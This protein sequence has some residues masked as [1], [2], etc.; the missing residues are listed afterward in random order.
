MLSGLPIKIKLILLAGV[1]VVGALILSYLVAVDAQRR[2][3][4]AK[5]L[6]SIEDLAELAETIS[7]TVDAIQDERMATAY[8]LGRRVENAEPTLRPQRTRVDERTQSLKDFFTSRD[9]K[10]LPPRL[11][12]GIRSAMHILEKQGEVR[13]AVLKEG[14]QLEELN[15]HSHAAIAELVGATAALT[16]LSDD[17]VMLRNISG[18]VSV[19]ELKERAAQEQALLAYV[20]SRSE[21]PPGGYKQL[22]NLVTEQTV[23]D[24]VLRRSTSAD[25]VALYESRLKGQDIDRALAIRQ[26]GLD[27]MDDNFGVDAAE[28]VKVQGEKVSLLRGLSHK[29][30]ER[31]K[32]AANAR[33]A[34][35]N[36]AVQ[37]SFGVSAAVVLASLLLALVISLGISR[38]VHALVHAAHEVQ[39]KQDF[40]I[41]AVKKTNDELGKLTD[42]FNHMLDGIQKRDQELEHHRENLE[43]TVAQ[44]TAELEQ[45]NEAM[46]VVLDNVEQ[47]LATI[48]VDGT[49]QAERSA[50]FNTWFDSPGL[51]AQAPFFEILAAN[52][53][54][55]KQMMELG[56]EGLTDGFLPTDMAAD[57]IPNKLTRNGRHY[58]LSYKP[59]GQGE[60]FHGALLMVT[61]V[62]EERARKEKEA[63]QREMIAVFEAVMRDRT[64]FI[65]FFNDTERMVMDVVGEAIG[66]DAVLKRVIHTIKGNSGIYGITSVADVCHGLE[67]ACIDE[68]RRPSASERADLERSWGRF[69][70]QVRLFSAEKADNIVE[71]DHAELEKLIAVVKAHAAHA[72]IIEALEGLKHEPTQ[73]RFERIGEQTRRLADKL[74]KPGLKIEVQAHHVRLPLERWGNFWSAFV[75]VTRNAVDHGI[76]APGERARAK[77]PVNGTISFTSKIEGGDFIIEMQDDG[78]GVDWDRVKTKAKER[79]LS[80]AT[81]D[82]LVNALFSDGLS[83]R[84][85]TTDTSGRGI[86][87]SAVRDA[88]LKLGGRIDVLSQAGQGTTVRITVPK[89]GNDTTDP[90][91][92]RAGVR[93]SLAPP[94]SSLRPDSRRSA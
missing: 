32:L 47:G 84:D 4:S 38:A 11:A 31:V 21:F 43:H 77:K 56:W 76:E 81:R 92:L 85:E 24:E 71:V 5:A 15:T 57:Q 80:H 18:L 59:M 19:M 7:V 45:R 23:F 93:P 82:D 26:I 6:G 67:Q 83:T 9:T 2:L 30:N 55:L 1:P 64:G 48:N 27:T 12:E 40:N 74:G 29:L 3:E 41:R 34:A 75:H 91:S 66:D 36:K 49:L 16:T 53:N 17:G 78:R 25:L 44:R 79:K 89:L 87:M 42:A 33:L 73:V 28:W 8:A 86:G 58:E 65:E 61:D 90:Q 68:Q 14:G 13:A 37:T 50:V 63:Q 69:A 35:A 60:A 51:S 10:A 62:T 39:T 22:V 72:K 70:S 88:V 20:F 52:D 46:R 54:S 94:P